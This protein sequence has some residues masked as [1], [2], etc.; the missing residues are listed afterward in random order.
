MGER[1][2]LLVVA[3]LRPGGIGFGE[4]A[5]AEAPTASPLVLLRG[6]GAAACVARW[7]AAS[8]RFFFVVWDLAP[9][10]APALPR[11]G[12]GLLT[13]FAFFFL[14]AMRTIHIPYRDC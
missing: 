10:F 7:G 9:T 2:L 3:L 1:H 11:A 14:A 12:A 13:R 4:P 5:G 8:A 6:R